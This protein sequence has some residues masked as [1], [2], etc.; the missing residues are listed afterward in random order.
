MKVVTSYDRRGKGPPIAIY[1]SHGPANPFPLPRSLWSTDGK[2]G[3]TTV[4]SVQEE[5]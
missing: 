5:S 2:T 1:T 4:T 3:R